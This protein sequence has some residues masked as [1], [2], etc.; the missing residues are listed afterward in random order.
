[1]NLSSIILGHGAHS[2]PMCLDDREMPGPIGPRRHDLSE[3]FADELGRRHRQ[4]KQDN[5]A[6][7]RERG[8]PCE[9][10]EILVEGEQNSALRDRAGQD[11]FVIAAG[12]IGSNPGD[13]MPGTAK[14]SNG[15]TRPVLV[16]EKAQTSYPVLASG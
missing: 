8:A 2:H 9:L 12:G 15:V 5:A 6:I 14:G 13:V 4:T 11:V 7:A 1:M 3:S 10:A 16:R